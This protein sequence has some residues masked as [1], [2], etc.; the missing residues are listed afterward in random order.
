MLGSAIEAAVGYEGDDGWGVAGQCGGD[1][2]W[3]EFAASVRYDAVVVQAPSMLRGAGR[4]KE[5]LT[6]FQMV[7]DRSPLPVVLADYGVARR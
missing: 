1:F 3:A 2:G 6:Y 5:M 7:A 4:A